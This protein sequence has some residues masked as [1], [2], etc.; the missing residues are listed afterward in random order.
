MS[1]YIQRAY[2]QPSA[3]LERM[4]W[5]TDGIVSVHAGYQPGELVTKPITFDGSKLTVNIS[6]S[7]AGGGFVEIQDA[8]GKPIPGFTLAEC[9][10][11]N[12]DD[13]ARVVSWKNGSDASSLAGKP[14]RLRFRMKDADL[15]AFQFVK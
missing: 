11:L 8:A 9:I 6:S 14:V 4:T 3:H 1:M 5:R 7:A 13:L 2:G 15:Y 12:T 10:E